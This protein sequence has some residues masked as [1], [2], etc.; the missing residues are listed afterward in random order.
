MKQTITIERIERTTVEVDVIEPMGKA[1]IEAVANSNKLGAPLP[2][3][4]VSHSVSAWRLRST[5]DDREPA[6]KPKRRR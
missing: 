1:T 5:T 2:G 6:P 3:T 4:S